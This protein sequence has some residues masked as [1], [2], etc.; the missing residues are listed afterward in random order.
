MKEKFTLASIAYNDFSGCCTCV[1]SFNWGVVGL[2]LVSAHKAGTW[3]SFYHQDPSLSSLLLLTVKVLGAIGH[4]TLALK[5]WQLPFVP[6]SEKYGGRWVT[7]TLSSGQ[8]CWGDQR[9][10]TLSA[11]LWDFPLHLHLKMSP[12]FSR[13]WLLMFIFNLH[14]IKMNQ[15]CLYQLQMVLTGAL[16]FWVSTSS[17]GVFC[18]PDQLNWLATF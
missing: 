14:V 10:G 7:S 5:N 4:H 15:S 11:W 8:V 9:L 17:L 12:P 6:V 1:I 2:C 3:L 16:G 13:Q 18:A